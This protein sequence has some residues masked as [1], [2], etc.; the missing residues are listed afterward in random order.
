MDQ[1]F[2]I[3]IILDKVSE[4]G[5]PGGR[6]GDCNLGKG[7]VMSIQ[8][9]KSQLRGVEGMIEGGRRQSFFGSASV[10]AISI[11]AWSLV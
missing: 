5:G 4:D 1:D 6:E 10:D 7:F 3:E 9:G 8:I 11:G 2:H